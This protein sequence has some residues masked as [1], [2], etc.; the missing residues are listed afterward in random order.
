M[1]T[2]TRHRLELVEP[3]PEG[4][5][6]CHS[7]FDEREKIFYL[8]VTNAPKDK[9]PHEGERRWLP[10]RNIIET[11]EVTEWVEVTDKA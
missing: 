9:L 2:E 1:E 4:F 7:Q 5:R 8:L 11:R 3:I 10:Y 6:A